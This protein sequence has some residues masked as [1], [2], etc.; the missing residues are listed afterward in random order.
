MRIKWVLLL[1]CLIITSANAANH[2]V[3]LG[4][5]RI[6]VKEYRYGKGA[7]YIHLHQNETTALSAAKIVAYA[8]GGRVLTLSHPG[9]RNIVFYNHKKRYEFDP[10]RI[11][12]DRGIKQTLLEF[13]PYSKT[14]A[15]E[16]KK[17]SHVIKALLGSGKIIAAHNN[18]SYSLKYYLPGH[19][20]AKDTRALYHN[21]RQ[22]YRN[23]FVVTRR[24]DYRRLKHEKYNSVLQAR[25]PTD[26]GSLSVFLAKQRYVNVEAGYD[27]L[28]KQIKMLKHA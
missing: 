28:H 25:H 6:I 8:R 14:A 24:A 21:R 1:V 7:T 17:L 16:V 9:G 12:T 11:F 4:Q 13:G 3:V 19:A 26:D 22:Y 5:T 27:Q 10:N 18:E 2:V 20:L 23:F 15:R